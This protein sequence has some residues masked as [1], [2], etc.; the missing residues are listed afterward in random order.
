M[1]EGYLMMPTSGDPG[2]QDLD[3]GNP[4]P[5]PGGLEVDSLEEPDGNPMPGPEVTDETP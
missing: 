4:M 1:P 3:D 5:G 2:D